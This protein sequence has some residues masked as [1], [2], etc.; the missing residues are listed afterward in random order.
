M[1]TK[2]FLLVTAI[3]EGGTG[4]G[5]LVLPAIALA[6]LLGLQAPA[7]DMVVI[8]RVAGSAL[9]AIGVLSGMASR[10]RGGPALRGVLAGILVYDTIVAALL[11][12]AGGALGMSGPL[13]W[14]AVVVHAF[15]AVWCAVSVRAA[16]ANVNPGHQ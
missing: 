6:L 11:A 16:A 15:L 5:L 10:D 7:P 12:H 2:T 9:L 1:A 3:G 4:L 13:L 8:S 14:P